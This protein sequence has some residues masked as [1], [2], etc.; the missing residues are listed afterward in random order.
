MKTCF[1]L[2]F[3]KIPL[4]LS[5]IIR[6]LAFDK[7]VENGFDANYLAI[8][9][10]P[11]GGSNFKAYLIFGFSENNKNDWNYKP[12]KP[13]IYPVYDVVNDWDKWSKFKYEAPVKPMRVV[14]NEKYTAIVNNDGVHVECQTFTFGVIKELCDAV[15]KM[16]D[17][18][19]NE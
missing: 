16:E 1:Q 5:S 6:K 4:E 13:E 14:L 11:C 17:K 9:N 12:F 8:D 7:L 15:L 3:T 18:T 19:G 2:D 10:P